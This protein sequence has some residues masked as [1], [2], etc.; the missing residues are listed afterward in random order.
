MSKKS[1]KNSEKF[2]NF[3]ARGWVKVKFGEDGMALRAKN[4]SGIDLMIAS[5]ALQN[6]AVE[7]LKDEL[8]NLGDLQNYF[9]ENDC[10][11]PDCPVHGKLDPD[12]LPE[13]VLPSCSDSNDVSDVEFNESGD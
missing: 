13:G 8:M 1:K 6:S 4:V 5:K 10:G 2:K 11:N 9:L 12:Q 3:K 7:D